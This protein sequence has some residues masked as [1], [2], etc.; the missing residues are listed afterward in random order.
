V[1]APIIIGRMRKLMRH[2]LQAL[3]LLI[4]ALISALTAMRLAIHGREVSVPDLRGKTPAEAR[5][6]ADHAGLAIA[7]ERSYYS[8]TVPEGKVLSQVPAPGSVVR[9]GWEVRLALSLGPQ[10]VTIPQLIGSSER[11]VNLTLA[12]RGIEVE[13]VA[14]TSLPGSNANEVIAQDPSAN[15]TNVSSPKV[16]IL[17]GE[18]DPSAAFVMPNFT[19]QVLGTVTNTLHDAGFSVGRVTMAAIPPPPENASAPAAESA[20]GP[21]IPAS[22]SAASIIVSQE[23]SPGAKVVAGSAVNFVVK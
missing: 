22:P 17:V 21:L 16:S 11:A 1:K 8:A 2:L 5:P 23:P 12:Q 19:G 9:R 3:V 4:V 18:G 6:L 7:V 10:R 20:P 14:R 15:S 13:A